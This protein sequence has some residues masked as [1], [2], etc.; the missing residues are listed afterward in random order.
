ME[1]R[2]KLLE[3]VAGLPLL[4]QLAT[5]AKSIGVPVFAVLPPEKNDRSFALQGIDIKMITAEDARLGMAHSL[6][7]GI[8]GLSNDITAVV[9]LPADMPEITADDFFTMAE[10]YATSPK[11]A[12]L[13][14]TSADGKTGHPVIFPSICFAD[15]LAL[16]GDQGARSVIEKHATVIKVPLPDAHA[17][18]DLDTPADWAAWRASQP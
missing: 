8:K 17:L 15:L 2:D 16:K 4:R 12:I 5:R 3:P 18:T 6:S 13:R 1:G 14:A 9:I 11:D 10:A 7:A